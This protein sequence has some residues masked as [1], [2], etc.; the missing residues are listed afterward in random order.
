ML[1]NLV[2][3]LLLVLAKLVPEGLASKS[4]MQTTAWLTR[5][6]PTMQLSCI[7]CTQQHKTCPA[8]N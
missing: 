8:C 6:T 4:H 7:V 2:I 5:A 3:M 1:N